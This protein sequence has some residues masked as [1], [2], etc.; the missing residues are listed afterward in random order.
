[1]ASGPPDELARRRDLGCDRVAQ[2]EG[3]YRKW[4]NRRGRQ[5]FYLSKRINGRPR[6]VYVG[7]GPVT[8]MLAAEVE[9]RKQVR[10]DASRAW[11]AWTAE[12]A[13]AENPL[14]DL[15][16]G[17]N[18][19]PLRPCWR[20]AITDTIAASGGR[21]VS[22]VKFKPG[23]ALAAVTPVEVHAII[24]AA[25]A[26]DISALPALKQALADHPELV[27]RLGDLAAHVERG[28][29][30][31]VAGPSFVAAEAIAAHLARMRQEL[32]D[33]SAS[34]LEKLLIKRLV[35]CWLA[36]HAA[37]LRKQLDK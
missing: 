16:A 24:A 14:D 36:C 29:V 34:P 37:E 12:V 21:V 2:V 6:A 20:V 17:W 4:W 26:G 25:N 3:V 10:A 27:E 32:G 8:E 23:E 1:L 28:L 19:S 11:A 15:C 33:A 31:L 9:S 18:C 5:Y 22:V 7:T 13:V 35:L 30:A